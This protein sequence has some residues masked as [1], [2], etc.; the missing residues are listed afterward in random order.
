VASSSALTSRGCWSSLRAAKR[1]TARGLL[2]LDEPTAALDLRHQLDVIAAAKTRAARGTTVVAILHDLNLAVLLARRI[3]VLD[4]GRID[5][6]G[7][8]DATITDAVLE[9]VFG[10]AQAVGTMPA[11]GTPFILPHAARKAV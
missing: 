5:A 8:P 4:R 10:V 1:P 11:P 3:V 6:D 7:P 9:R 2:L